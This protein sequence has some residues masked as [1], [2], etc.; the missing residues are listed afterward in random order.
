MIIPHI[1][2][3]V[4]IYPCA[5]D[6]PEQTFNQWKKRLN[7]WRY[8]WLAKA[9]LIHACC[10][11]IVYNIIYAYGLDLLYFG[12]TG[13]SF[14]QDTYLFPHISYGF[15]HWEKLNGDCRGASEWTQKEINRID[16]NKN[17]TV[18]NVCRI[19]RSFHELELQKK[20]YKFYVMHVWV[21]WVSY[22]R[23]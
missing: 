21:Q 20:M 10:R 4:I 23:L 8:L 12:M 22:V 9:L 5:T 1:T 18:R 17:N 3:G 7:L 2:M 15:W 19:W 13:S 6:S 11:D 14:F 16:Q